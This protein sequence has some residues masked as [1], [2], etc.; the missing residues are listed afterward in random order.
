[1]LLGLIYI[2]PMMAVNP[3]GGGSVPNDTCIAV[4]LSGECYSFVEGS[5]PMRM[6]RKGNTN[7]SPAKVPHVVGQTTI[8]KLVY[9]VFDP[10]EGNGWVATL[11]GWAD[12]YDYYPDIV[13]PNTIKYDGID[14][15]VTAVNQMAFMNG[16]GIESVKFGANVCS[17]FAYAFY[18][19]SLTKLKIPISVMMIWQSAFMYNPLEKVTFEN[20]YKTS[21]PLFIGPFAFACLRIKDFEIPARNSPYSYTEKDRGNPFA[22]NPQLSS[23]SINPATGSWGAPSRA[24]DGD[25]EQ[26]TFEIINDALCV[27]EGSGENRWVTVVA[28]PSGNTKESFELTENLIDV[29]DEAFSQSNNLRSIRLKASSTSESQPTK[30]AVYGGAF[31]DNINLEDLSLEAQ[32]DVELSSDM[33]AGCTGLETVE[34]GSG[35]TNYSV[36]DDVI[37]QTIN[38]EKTLVCYPAGKVDDV[39]TIP[40]GVIA[41]DSYAFSGNPLIWKVVMPSGLK[42][43]G[44]GAF[45]DCI[46]LYSAEMPNTLEEISGRAFANSQLNEITIPASV[47]IIDDDAFY[48]EQQISKVTVHCLT[49][50]LSS[51]GDVASEIF[52]ATT[53]DQAILELPDNVASETFTN[54][55]AWA[56]K[57]VQ[58]AGID[59]IASDNSQC[60]RIDGNTISSMN[61]QPMEIFNIDGT[62]AGSGMSFTVPSSGIYLV[63]QGPNIAKISI[64]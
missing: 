21:P 26:C 30:L 14:V 20:P 1:M 64:R 8:N 61:N 42:T 56:F 19:C 17:I 13:I 4:S 62:L 25:G 52:S 9:S 34:L 47:S 58:S 46:R 36:T 53:L 37:Y 16:W 50:P 59:D 49:P 35:I 12:S 7:Q 41:I 60:F 48:T 54:H 15:P 22:R 39:F 63:Q 6:T 57:Q 10:D 33:V 24:S 11:M 18:G 23:F 44:Y 5:Q 27:V 45:Y 38:G 2:L 51:T 28:Y 3:G 55:P 32:G 29:N 43:I 31:K 40:N